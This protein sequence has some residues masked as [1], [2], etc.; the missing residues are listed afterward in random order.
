MKAFRGKVFS[1]RMEKAVVVVM[2]RSYRHPKYGKI[3]RIRRKIHAANEIGAKIGEEVEISPIR[4]IS[5]TIA[6]R[7]TKIIGEEKKGL[8]EKEA[9]ENKIK[10]RQ[11]GRRK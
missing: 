10:I 4:P 11:K 6:F 3:L 2:E 5:K 1:D 8:G 9:K 7:V